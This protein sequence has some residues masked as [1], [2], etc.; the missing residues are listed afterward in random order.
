MSN[1]SSISPTIRSSTPMVMS[2]ANAAKLVDDDGQVVMVD[3]KFAQQLVQ[4][5]FQARTQ[6]SP[7]QRLG[8]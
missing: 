2:P 3:A 8:C 4:S 5:L 7:Q 1:S 6:P